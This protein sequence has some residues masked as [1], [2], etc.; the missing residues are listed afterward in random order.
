ME[1][2]QRYFRPKPLVFILIPLI[3]AFVLGLLRWWIHP[4]IG[5][6]LFAVGTV[7]GIF[8]LDAAE[9]FFNLH[10]SPFRSVVFAVGLMIVALFVVTSSGNLM[11]TGLVVSLY[12][13]IILLQ[14]GEMRVRGHL[15]S[16]FALVSSPVSHTAQKR[17]LFA[18]IAFFGVLTLLFLLS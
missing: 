1:G 16:W 13:N 2:L 11:A 8:L 5:A 15:D 10:P 12:L 3:Y 4:P 7:V 17:L 9:T 18:Y 14:L 6:I